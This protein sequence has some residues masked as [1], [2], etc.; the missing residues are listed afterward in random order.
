MSHGNPAKATIAA[1]ATKTMSLGASST[2]RSTEIKTFSAA[3]RSWDS[4]ANAGGKFGWNPRTRL[5]PYNQPD[6][7]SLG[8]LEK[9]HTRLRDASM[10]YVTR[11]LGRILSAR[12]I[13]LTLLSV[14]LR[15]STEVKNS[16]ARV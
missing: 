16:T 7:Q 4:D 11:A 1:S 3:I 15:P 5:P 12:L 8:V 13:E 10:L 2:S 14:F 6:F 9:A